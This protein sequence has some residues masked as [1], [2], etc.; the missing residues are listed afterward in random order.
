MSANQSEASSFI[1][2]PLAIKT[3]LSTVRAFK[4]EKWVQHEDGGEVRR[5]RS[6][7]LNRSNERVR[8]RE[9]FEVLVV[10]WETSNEVNYTV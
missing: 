8:S 5:R 7:R 9:M 6:P 4:P 2:R 10:S 1:T 3:G